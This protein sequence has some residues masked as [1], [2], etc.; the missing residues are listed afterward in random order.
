MSPSSSGDIHLEGVTF[1]SGTE[2]RRGARA[3][4][5]GA[6]VLWVDVW[7][8]CSKAR[9]WARSRS[10]SWNWWEKFSSSN[11]PSLSWSCSGSGSGSESRRR[12]SYQGKSS[13]AE[14]TSREKRLGGMAKVAEMAE[15]AE[16]A[17]TA[18][19]TFR[20]VWYKSKVQEESK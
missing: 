15:T 19:T 20:M 14:G 10:S 8:S 1:L 6:S 13:P 11:R 7:L 17:K 12:C 18:K 5:V 3:G 9:P 4:L 16:T 2:V